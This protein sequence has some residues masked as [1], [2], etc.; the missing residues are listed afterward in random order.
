M[1]GKE[2]IPSILSAAIERIA[3]E[4]RVGITRVDIRWIDTGSISHPRS[5]IAAVDISG[6]TLHIE[7]RRPPPKEP[8]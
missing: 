5:T 6:K 3:D 1:S 8:K 2:P 7:D 4:H